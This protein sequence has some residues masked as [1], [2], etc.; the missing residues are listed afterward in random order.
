MKLQINAS[1]K[2][3]LNIRDA[4][5]ANAYQNKFIISLDFEMLDSTMPYYQPGPGNRL[6]YEIRF[7]NCNRVIVSPGSSPKPGSKY[8]IMDRSL[9]YEIVTHLD[10]A[11][12]IVMEYQSM[13]FCSK[14]RQIPVNKS[15]MT[16]SRS[17]LDI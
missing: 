2:N 4:A 16:W 12:H 13:V 17:L 1:D 5:I 9:E 15:D 10:L 11:K 7:N 14:E 6:C 3:A 8:K